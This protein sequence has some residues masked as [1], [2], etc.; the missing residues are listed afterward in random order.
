MSNEMTKLAASIL[1]FTYIPITSC[2]NTSGEFPGVS[3]LTYKS[4]LRTENEFLPALMKYYRWN[5]IGIINVSQGKKVYLNKQ[6]SLW[7][8]FTAKCQ[9]TSVVSENYNNKTLKKVKDDKQLKTLIVLGEGP[10][11]YQLMK[12]VK[13]KN[14]TSRKWIMYTAQEKLKKLKKNLSLFWTGMHI[15][16]RQIYNTLQI[17]LSLQ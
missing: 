17:K 13:E 6:S 2:S 11:L 9:N 12:E 3:S 14:L 7:K 5:Y 16:D 10:R 4:E 1:S 8:G 15:L